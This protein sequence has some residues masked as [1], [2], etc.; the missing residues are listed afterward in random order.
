[1][2]DSLDFLQLSF[3][4][5]LREIIQ[6]G[7]TLKEM[8]HGM[9]SELIDLKMLSDLNKDALELERGRAEG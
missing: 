2:I 1:M 5:D 8:L 6:G 7:I 3:C 9:H 4:C